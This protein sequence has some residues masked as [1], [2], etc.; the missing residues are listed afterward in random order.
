MHHHPRVEHHG[1]H[2][3]RA[4]PPP[5]P[6]YCSCHGH[7]VHRQH[8][9]RWDHQHRPPHGI[10]LRKLFC[11]HI[12][13]GARRRLLGRQ[14]ERYLLPRRDLER[15]LHHRGQDGHHYERQ[16]QRRQEGDVRGRRR[17]C[18]R[19]EGAGGRGVHRQKRDRREGAVG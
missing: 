7:H 2:R 11:L 5:P 13:A 6:F 1:E 16:H 12:G 18:A 8:H 14:P 4:I 10:Q 9:R 15:H 17:W 19:G 3:R